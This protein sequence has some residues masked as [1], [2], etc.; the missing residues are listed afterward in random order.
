MSKSKLEKDSDIRKLSSNDY[1]YLSQKNREL[2]NKNHELIFRNSVLKKK[3]SDLEQEKNLNAQ[4]NEVKYERG[5][6]FKSYIYAQIVIAISVIILAL[7]FHIVYLSV[8]DCLLYNEG[9]PNCWYKSWAGIRVHASFFIDL[10]L[11]LLIGA[12][13]ILILLLIR[14]ALHEHSEKLKNKTLKEIELISSQ[15][16]K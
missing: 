16:S 3:V 7:A 6:K 15:K 1:N 4:I 14:K 8:T 2:F 5:F 10:T 11:Y 12:Q 9:N 13:I